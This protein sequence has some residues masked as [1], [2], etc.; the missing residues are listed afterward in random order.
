[1]H[2][3]YERRMLTTHIYLKTGLIAAP[4]APPATPPDGD[5]PISSFNCLLDAFFTCFFASSGISTCV[6][7]CVCSA[8][9][10]YICCC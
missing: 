2:V 5:T 4:P 8:Y 7:V 1:M 9:T 3:S 10:L 6:C